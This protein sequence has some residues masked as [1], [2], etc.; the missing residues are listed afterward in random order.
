MR[1]LGPLL[2]VPLLA[3]P[4][5]VPSPA[6]A[7]DV[8]YETVT[9]LD[10][11]G[12]LGTMVRAAARLGGGSTETVETTYIKGRK[13]RTDVDRSSTIVDMDARRMIFLDHDA[14]TYHVMS[15]DAAVAM[16]E[17]VGQQLEAAR[18]GER[19]AGEQDGQ[20][21][22]TFRFSVDRPGQRQQVA[23]YDAERFFLILE[24]EG[25][26]APEDGDHPEESGTLVV[27]TDLW[28]STD[29]PAYRARSDFDR[30][31]A[32]H[33]ADAGA[34]IS[35]ALA[36]IL[37][38]DPSLQTALELSAAEAEKMEGLPVR[39]VTTIVAV[40]PGHTFDRA[41]VTEPQQTGGGAR[42]ALGRLGRAAAGAAG[43]PPPA[44]AAGEPTQTVIMTVTSEI[45][46]IST[47]RLDDGLFEVP[48]GYRQVQE[49]GQGR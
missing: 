8:Q 5:A 40:A 13:M 34:S 45:R 22:V 24:A 37:A 28:T 44:G 48:E 14:R 25:E 4:L 39:T 41:L 21:R 9:K 26:H 46:N 2:L 47:R 19:V 10:L 36:G 35:E 30:A 27:V 7:Q 18:E 49:E 31:A 33:Y 15:L 32:R 1:T 29:V 23:G 38:E 6:A 11:P 17:E 42:A 3:G 16:A 20:G 43:Q 12:A